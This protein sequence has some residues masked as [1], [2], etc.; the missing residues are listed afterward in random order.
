[1]GNDHSLF[2]AKNFD[3]FFEFV[4]FGT[5]LAYWISCLLAKARK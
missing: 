5:G 2:A 1:L 4:W 3:N